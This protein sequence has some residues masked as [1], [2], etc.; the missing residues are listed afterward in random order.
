[1]EGTSIDWQAVA[2][3]AERF[4]PLGLDW[5]LSPLRRVLGQFARAA[6]GEVD[7][8]FWES[9]YRIHPAE[10][11][12]HSASTLGWIGV[13][14]PYLNDPQGLPTVRNP[15]LSGERDLDELLDPDRTVGRRRMS[16]A[17]DPGY[18]VEAQ[19][20]S[21]LA[22]APFT[23]DERDRNGQRIHRW[24]MELLGGFVGVT[25]EAETLRLRPEIGWAVRERAGSE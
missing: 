6:G 4:A 17:G 2:D 11:S 15:W 19:F 21:G 14:F 13:L 18:L 5:W 16:S 9:I 10:E 23:W 25:Q 7:R 24:D 8:P 1:L 20:P 22:G 12:S 3:G